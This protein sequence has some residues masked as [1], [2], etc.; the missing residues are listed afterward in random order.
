MN[1]HSRVN[2]A[3]VFNSD[4]RTGSYS[5]LS[6]VKVFL[7]MY[8]VVHASLLVTMLARETP[9]AGRNDFDAL[10]SRSVSRSSLFDASSACRGSA[11]ACVGIFA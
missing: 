8:K 5:K 10:P 7:A 6:L 3:Q 2:E 11:A 4:L 9:D 1:G